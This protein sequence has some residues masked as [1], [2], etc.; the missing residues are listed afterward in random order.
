MLGHEERTVTADTGRPVSPTAEAILGAPAGSH[1]RAEAGWDHLRTS[2]RLGRTAAVT[3][4]LLIAAGMVSLLVTDRH[5]VG[6]GAR[7]FDALTQL[8]TG[9]GLSTDRYSLVG[10]LFAAPV[11]WLGRAAGDPG[12]GSP[13]TTWSC[14]PSPSGCC[15]GCSAAGWTRCCCAGS[16]CSWWPAA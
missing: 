16:C 5:L 10:P 1:A 2:R 3:D 14:S 9:G 4:Y 15:S 7:R 12:A 6:D 13:T 8:L 11:W